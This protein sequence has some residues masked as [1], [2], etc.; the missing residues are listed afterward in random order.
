MSDLSECPRVQDKW[1]HLDWRVEF[2]VAHE[3]GFASA[4]SSGKMRAFLGTVPPLP[5]IKLVC[6]FVCKS[7]RLCPGI[8]TFLLHQ[9]GRV[10]GG[11]VRIPGH[12]PPESMHSTVLILYL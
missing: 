8:C 1:C 11:N 12:S 10:S 4:V 3:R 9:A 2:S 5:G 7:S 6:E